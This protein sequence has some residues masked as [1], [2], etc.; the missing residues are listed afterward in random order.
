MCSSLDDL[1]VY[2]GQRS[3]IFHLK[4]SSYGLTSPFSYSL[5][6]ANLDPR[7]RV[8]RHLRFRLH[9]HL[10]LLQLFDFLL[11]LFD[12][13]VGLFDLSFGLWSM[14]SNIFFFVTAMINKLECFNLEIVKG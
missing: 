10:L 2:L 6:K 7:V 3:L 4:S 11:Q 14:F 1:T 5:I 12:L 9:G 13:F 8:N